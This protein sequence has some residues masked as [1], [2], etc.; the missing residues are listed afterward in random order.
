MVHQ[1]YFEVLTCTGPR[2]GDV[3]MNKVH[4]DPAFKKWAF[5]FK[6]KTLDKYIKD[7][8]ITNVR[9]DTQTCKFFKKYQTT[10]SDQFDNNNLIY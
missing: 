8:L 2:T 6:K 7:Y 5:K 9:N 10:Y 3:E 1:V 4:I